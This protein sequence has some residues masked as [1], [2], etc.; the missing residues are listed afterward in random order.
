M[1]PVM[2]AASSI[3]SSASWLARSAAHRGLLRSKKLDSRVIS[4]GNLQVGGSGK[5]PIVGQLAREAAERKLSVC[6]LSRGYR[7]GW[8]KSGG[9]IEPGLPPVDPVAAGDEPALLQMLAPEAW[10]GVGADRIKQFERARK[11]FGRG[12]D[13]VLLDDGFQHW[14]IKKDLE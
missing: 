13:L 3:W 5:T 14:K 10:I 4:V 6:I 1:K 2:W 9:L 8:E 7:G 11:H 12:F